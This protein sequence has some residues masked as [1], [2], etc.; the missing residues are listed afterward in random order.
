MWPISLIV[1][2]ASHWFSVHAKSDGRQFSSMRERWHRRP[3]VGHW[4]QKWLRLPFKWNGP[5]LPSAL[6]HCL[7]LPF[8]CDRKADVIMW[9]KISSLEQITSSFVLL[10]G[11]RRRIAKGNAHFLQDW[12]VM[13]LK[14]CGMFVESLTGRNTHKHTRTHQKKELSS[15]QWNKKMDVMCLLNKCMQTRKHAACCSRGL[16]LALGPRVRWL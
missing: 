9:W 15:R 13:S 12:R 4:G 7:L 16:N 1:S 3:L 8:H 6:E 10:M 5:G 14:V 11:T 2:M